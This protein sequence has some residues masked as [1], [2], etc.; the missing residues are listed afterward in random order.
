LDAED[1]LALAHFDRL[2][3]AVELI[4]ALGGGWA[5]RDTASVQM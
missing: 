4:R 3:A 1:S 2:I 5:E